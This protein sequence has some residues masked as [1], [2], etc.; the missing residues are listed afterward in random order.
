MSVTTTMVQ[1][2]RVE[3]IADN[4]HSTLSEFLGESHPCSIDALRISSLIFASICDVELL[5]QGG[6][7][8]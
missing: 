2:R 3:E 5:E 7:G 4:L 6:N 8:D 1:L